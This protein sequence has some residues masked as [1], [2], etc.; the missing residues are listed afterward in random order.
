[1]LRIRDPDLLC[2][3]V[4]IDSSAILAGSHCLTTLKIGEGGRS[5]RVTLSAESRL[6]GL[7]VLELPSAVSADFA[8]K[9]GPALMRPQGSLDAA[10]EHEEETDEVRSSNAPTEFLREARPPLSS[11]ECRVSI[12]EPEEVEGLS[13]AD[14]SPT[15][16]ILRLTSWSFQALSAFRWRLLINRKRSVRMGEREPSKRLS[17]RSEEVRGP[18]PGTE[19][20]DGRDL[21]EVV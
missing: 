4:V 18:R 3:D 16:D 9:G 21:A 17:E 1:M 10:V 14:V 6:P 12:E 11:F 13:I 20:N 7:E 5:L 8:T 19:D 2:L 15:G